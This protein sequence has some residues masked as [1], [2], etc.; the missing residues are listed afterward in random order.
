MIGYCLFIRVLLL[1]TLCVPH[2]RQL[3]SSGPYGRQN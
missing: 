3:V 1:D 2:A